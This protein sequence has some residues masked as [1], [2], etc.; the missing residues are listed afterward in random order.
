MIKDKLEN[1]HKFFEGLTFNEEKHQYKVKDISLKLSVSGVI[2]KFV[3]E[4]DF[5]EIALEQ[6]AKHGM[7]EGTMKQ[8]WEYN[9]EAACAF[10][11]KVHFFGELYPFHRTLK[12]TNKHEEAIVKFWNDLPEHIIPVKMELQMYHKKFMFAGTADIILYDTIKK[13]FIIADY[14]TN[15]DLFK[16]F[17]KKTLLAP[18]NNLLDSPYSKYVLQLSFYQLLFE[19]TGYKVDS[20]RI[21][22]LKPDG[23]YEMYLTDDY[24]KPIMEYL[25]NNGI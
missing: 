3:T 17:R 15:K 13:V 18:F 16:N 23:N 12:P 11:T 9:K 24:R 14:K 22:W 20:R 21:V 6:D 4:V 19:Q 8:L 25:N 7:S 10:G 1:I 5:D 2:K